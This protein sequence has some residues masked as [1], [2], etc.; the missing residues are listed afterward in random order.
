[1][2]KRILS[3]LLALVL[4]FG[5]LPV[6]AHAGE[7]SNDYLYTIFEDH[8][9]INYYIGNSEDVV[10]PAQIEGLP[11]TIIGNAAFYSNDDLNSV[12]VP[13]NVIYIGNEAFANCDNLTIVDL[14]DSVTHIGERAFRN[15]ERL[16][17]IYLPDSV[18]HIGTQA[19]SL[20]ALEKINIPNSV[21][22]I[23]DSAFSDCNVLTSINIPESVIHIGSR[24]FASCDRLREILVDKNNP[25]YSSDNLG[26][27]FNKEKTLLIVAPMTI[28]GF[29]EIPDSVTHIND[30]AFNECRNLNNIDIPNTVTN[31][32]KNAFR[33][34][35]RLTNIDIPESVTC[36]QSAAFA[37]SSLDSIRFASNAPKFE[38]NIFFDVTTTAYYP[39]GNPT[40]TEDVMQ[41]YGGDITWVPYS[42]VTTE[43]PF[44]DVPAGCW[45]E[46][47]VLWALENGVTSGS[48]ETTFSPG[49]KCLRAHVVTFLWNA[50]KCPEPAAAASTFTDV[51]TGAWYEKPVLWA[52]EHGITSGTSATKFGAG[53]VCSRYQ[54]VFF[55]WKAAG[56]PEPKTTVNPFTDV[57]PGHFFYKA[58]LWAVENGITSGTSATTFGP[59]VPCNRA[60]VVTFLY[61]AYN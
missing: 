7:L 37:F 17:N 59:T 4:V 12:V 28:N 42:S 50:E 41:D 25:N 29:Y 32:G 56:S 10:I 47:P 49:D 34:C 6:T 3:L 60:Q 5:L 8:V 38:E 21:T 33:G 24:A 27:L 18:T 30:H 11:V 40:W 53:D 45:Y 22:H 15:C 13:N 58:V 48:S 26:V 20:G 55:L 44:T 9:E 31:I 2:Q 51:P 43:N 57:N 39:A 54:V 23:G 14:A 1:M 35:Y 46:A 19:F 61:A 52:V 36:I 16:Y